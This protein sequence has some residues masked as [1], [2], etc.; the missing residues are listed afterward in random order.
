MVTEKEEREGEDWCSLLFRM[1][2]QIYRRPTYSGAGSRSRRRFF[3]E[4][5]ALSQ[6]RGMDQQQKQKLV[7]SRGGEGRCRGEGREGRREGGV[8]FVAILRN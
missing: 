8:V 2:C 4:S 1:Q 6:R 3:G 7:E 5:S